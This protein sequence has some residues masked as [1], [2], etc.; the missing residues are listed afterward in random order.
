[1][2]SL[3]NIRNL[4]VKKAAFCNEGNWILF[5]VGNLKEA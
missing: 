1:M 2:I 3:L 5:E 4:N